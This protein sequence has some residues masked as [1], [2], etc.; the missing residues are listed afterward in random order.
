MTLRRRIKGSGITAREVS[1]YDLPMTREDIAEERKAVAAWNDALSASGL[2]GARTRHIR[3]TCLA[4]LADIPPGPCAEDSPAD[5]A[6]RIMRLFDCADAAVGDGDA[7]LA[8]DLAFKAGAEWASATMK[9]SWERQALTGQKLRDASEASAERRRGR[10][11]PETARVVDEMARLIAKGNS[12]SN[13]ARIAAE[14]GIGRSAMA[15]RQ[16]WARH[17]KK[18][19]TQA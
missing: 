3:A 5:F 8:A 14:R 17:A 15:N 12:Q 9:W 7:D 13:A 4:I 16:A 18:V 1:G 19:V 11:R 6:R 10:Q 2:F